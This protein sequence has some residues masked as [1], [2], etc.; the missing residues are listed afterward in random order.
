MSTK[1]KITILGATGSVGQSTAHVILSNPDLFDVCTVTANTN[2]NDL[3]ILAKKLN[4]HTAIIA[5]KTKEEDLKSLLNGS[6]IRV[7]S[8]ADEIERAAEEPLD[9]IMASIMGFAGLRPIVKG[10]EQ[11]TNIA[12]AN[13][14]P[15]VAAGGYITELAKKNNAKI[16]PVDSEHNAIFQVFENDN[17]KAIDKIILTASG[18][19]FLDWTTEDINNATP[20]QAIAHPNW[21]MGKKISVDSASMMNK[22]LEIIEAH[23]LFNMPAEKIDVVIH[24]Q[25]VVHSM[26]SYTDG[27]VLSQMG[28][29]DMKTPIAY[30]LGWPKRIDSHGDKLDIKKISELTFSP[31]DFNRFPALKYAYQCIEKGQIACIA[32]N[33]ANEI[34]VDMFLNG[35]IKFSDIIRSVQYALEVIY[36]KLPQT[37]PKT[38][39]DIEKLD[40]T[41]RIE[42]IRYLSTNKASA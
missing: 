15:L 26:V 21:T 42:T 2:V 27:S 22:A 38:I 11:G 5:D 16:L 1:K 32:F 20:E 18:G 23:Y 25:S 35:D 37:P 10:L 9:L 31:P 17:I 33:A 41:V 13:K 12:I 29:S 7:L 34:A 19:P 14:E 30:A 39:E 24:P 40:N 3:A 36:P 6:N 4:A 28:A 8:G